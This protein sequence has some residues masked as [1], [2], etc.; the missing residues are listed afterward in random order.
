MMEDLLERDFKT[1]VLNLKRTKGRCGESQ[2]N[3]V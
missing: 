2:E 1:P 3:N